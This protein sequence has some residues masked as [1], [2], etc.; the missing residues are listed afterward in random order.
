MSKIKNA[1]DKIK[2]VKTLLLS[3]YID[4]SLL[5]SDKKACYEVNND[6]FG[7]DEASTMVEKLHL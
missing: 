2:M 3:E 7:F 4:V 5:N 1:S 6:S